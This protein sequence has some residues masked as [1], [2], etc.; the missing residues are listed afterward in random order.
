MRINDLF[1]KW[2]TENHLTQKEAAELIGIS[3]GTYSRFEKHGVAGM[4]TAELI[5]IY[6]SKN[7]SEFGGEA[8]V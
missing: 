3:Q 5:Q 1:A 8:D 6:Y 4:K 7:K 2:R